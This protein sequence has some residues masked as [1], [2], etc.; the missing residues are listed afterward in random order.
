MSSVLQAGPCVRTNQLDYD[1]EVMYKVSQT[2][3]PG[4][5]LVGWLTSCTRLLNTSMSM[6]AKAPTLVVLLP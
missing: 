5:C 1:E 4:P 2:A 3:D 6:S